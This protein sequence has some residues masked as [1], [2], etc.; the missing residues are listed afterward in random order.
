MSVCWAPEGIIT[1]CKPPPLLWKGDWNETAA[2]PSQMQILVGHNVPAQQ[3]FIVPIYNIILY[4]IL[5]NS[6]LKITPL[7]PIGALGRI[8]K[9]LLLHR[10]KTETSVCIPIVCV[11]D[12]AR[13]EG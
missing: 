4:D 5:V 7:P 13:Q 3:V 6:P 11:L 9:H 10:N 12:D 2:I 1:D 8:A